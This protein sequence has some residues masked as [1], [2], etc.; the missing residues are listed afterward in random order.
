MRQ[1]VGSAIPPDARLDMMS[2][3]QQSG[4]NMRRNLWALTIVALVLA[5]LRPGHA[6]Q[7]DDI[8][9]AGVLRA[10]VFDSNPPFGARDP[11]SDRLVGYDIDVADAIAKHIGVGLQLVATNPA[12]RI[13][14]LQAGKVDLI[15]AYL[16]ITHER[17]EVIDFSILYFRTGVQL[18]VLAGDSNRF[19]DFVYSRIGVVRGTTQEEY[20]SHDFRAAQRLVFDDTPQA[21]QA[22]RDASVAAVA[23]DH[24]TLAGFLAAAPDRARFKILPVY[25]TEDNVGI[26]L[27][28]N[29]KELLDAM[30][31]E[32]LELEQSGAAPR[33]YHR[34]LDSIGGTLQERNFKIAV[35]CD[36]L[37][38][39][40]TGDCDR[41]L[42]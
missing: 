26:W 24:H 18:L 42:R 23:Q 36:A 7:L 39:W 13:P 30:N 37:T 4:R 22:L 15:V 21:M 28:K 16:T 27:P 34:W 31:G 41:Q 29:Q 20:L 19:E 25:I 2:R 6:S 40:A 38:G 1:Q 32:L 8:R 33:I 14:L 3:R 9:T 17:A 12:N 10:A 35:P 5:A 11:I